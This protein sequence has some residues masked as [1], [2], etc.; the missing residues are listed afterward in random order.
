MLCPI[1]SARGL[2]FASNEGFTFDLQE[3]ALQP[4]E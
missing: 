1:L 4:D 2:Q 3:R